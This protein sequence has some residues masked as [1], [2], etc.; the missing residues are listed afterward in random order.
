MLISE[1]ILRILAKAES[2]EIENLG[3]KSQFDCKL[4]SALSKECLELN[5]LHFMDLKQINREVRHSSMCFICLLYIT[6]NE[7]VSQFGISQ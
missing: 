1:H 2:L 7:I 5:R 3:W 6:T 4:F